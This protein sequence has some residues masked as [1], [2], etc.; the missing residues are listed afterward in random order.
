[1]MRSEAEG[2]T[3]RAGAEALRR[4]TEKAAGPV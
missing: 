1:M 4:E 3:A 2:P